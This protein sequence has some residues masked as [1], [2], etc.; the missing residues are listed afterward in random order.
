MR[1]HVSSFALSVFTLNLSKSLYT[2]SR[3]LF[4]SC[5]CIFCLLDVILTASSYKWAWTEHEKVQHSVVGDLTFRIE[6]IHCHFNVTKQYISRIF[7]WFSSALC[8]RHTFKDLYF[9]FVFHWQS[10]CEQSGRT[11][12]FLKR[13]VARF[14]FSQTK[15]ESRSDFLR[16]SSW[17]AN[18][19]DRLMQWFALTCA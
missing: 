1:R 15:W 10:E 8:R 6:L 11:C 5:I 14:T 17:E 3:S 18:R 7:Q 2:C 12:I 19:T 16:V 9:I 13:L 4:Y